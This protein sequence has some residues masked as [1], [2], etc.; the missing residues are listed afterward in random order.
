MYSCACCYAS[1]KLRVYVLLPYALVGVLV[2]VLN[3]LQ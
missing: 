1:V 3:L 2:Y